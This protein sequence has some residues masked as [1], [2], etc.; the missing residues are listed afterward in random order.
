MVLSL[1]GAFSGAL[2]YGAATVLQAV[3]MRRLAAVPPASRLAHRLWSARLFGVGM[4]LDGAGFLASV[5]ALRTLPLFL[6]QSVVA[7]SVAVTVVLAILFLGVRVRT[8][9]LVALVAI[10]VG[11]V[12]L[13]ASASPSEAGTLTRPQTWLLLAGVL[14]LALLA[15]GGAVRAGEAEAASP[16]TGF[17]IRFPRRRPSLVL[18]SVGAGLGFGGVGLAARVLVI[19]HPWWSGTR[20]PVLWALVGYSVV[21]FACYALALTAGPVT[22]VAAVTFGVETVVPAGI[23]L[24]FLGDSVRAGGAV[25]ALLGFVSTVGGC[26][27]LARRAEIADP[28]LT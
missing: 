16:W 20:D 14:P 13:A 23:G 8:G 4:L 10:G 11:L 9:E 22:V 28:P 24:A 7:S 25:L 26:L 12:A 17:R 5:V 3:G 1:L 21:G 15:A 6:V 18:L 27:A 2:F 19:P